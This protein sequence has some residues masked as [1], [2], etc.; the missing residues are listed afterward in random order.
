[1]TSFMNT[2]DKTAIGLSTLC[3]LQCLTLPITLAFLPTF[4]WLR[5][6]ADE[7]FHLW[8]LLAVLPVSFFALATGFTL[9][10]NR[11]VILISA[12]GIVILIFSALLGH[13][14]LGEAGEVFFTAVGSILV[15]TGHIQNL[16]Y[17]NKRQS[18]INS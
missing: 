10:K 6:F 2:V 16:K 4:T 1:M 17:R 11:Y 9:H 3:I 14:T 15:A 12:S 13:D 7:T 8:L 18:C 5:F